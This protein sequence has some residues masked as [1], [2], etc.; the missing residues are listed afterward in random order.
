MLKAMIFLKLGNFFGL[1]TL[2]ITI[3]IGPP[4]L[5][6][7]IGFLVKKK[8][9]KMGKVFFILGGLYLLIGLGFCGTIL[10]NN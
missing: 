5:L 10:M 4:I 3:M 8:W 1:I 7:I 6:T 9:P 2:I